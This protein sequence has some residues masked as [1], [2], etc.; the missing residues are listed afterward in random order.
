MDK[1]FFM[2]PEEFQ[3]LATGRGACIASNLIT[4]DGQ[5]VCFMYREEPCNQVDSGWRFMAGSEPEGYMNDA[6]RFSFYDIN[7]IANYDRSI[8]PFLDAPIGS[9]FERS[10]GEAEFVLVE[11]WTPS[12]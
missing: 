10:S 9:A 5:A 6:G 7:T 4:V 2:R 11:D 1:R 12:K 8:M 3:S